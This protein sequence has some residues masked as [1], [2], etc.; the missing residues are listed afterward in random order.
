MIETDRLYLRPFCEEDGEIIYQIYG[1][2][3]IM[4]YTPFDPLDREQAN[5][6]LQKIVQGW[7]ENPLVDYELAV[8]V[9]ENGEKIGRCHMQLDPETDSAMIGWMLL[10]K[11]WGKGYAAE[12]TK[13]LLDYC[14]DVL[15]VHRVYALCNPENEKS[16]RVLEKFHMRREAHLKQKCRYTKHGKSFWQDELIYAILDMECK[17]GMKN[18]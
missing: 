14:F 7:K 18:E 13:A 15:K 2:A 5:A 11:E 6:H 4:K 3:E 1:D 17:R 10:K 8:I 16:W 12:M 9:K